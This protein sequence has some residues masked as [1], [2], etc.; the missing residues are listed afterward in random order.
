MVHDRPEIRV[1]LA[2]NANVGKSLIFNQ[3][4]GM[5]QII[6]NWPG[7][8]V[9][10]AE[11][12]FVYK[13]FKIQMID[14]PGIY[15][16]STYSLE[17][18]VSRE[19]IALEKPDIVVNVVDS[20]VLER[21]LFFTLQLLE[22]G[23][24]LVLVLNL[25]DQ[26]EKKGISINSDKLE[27]I[28]GVPVIKTIARTGSGITELV[29]KIIELNEQTLMPPIIKYGK[30]IEQEINHV[31][32]LIQ[33]HGLEYP[34]RWLAIKILENDTEIIK[35]LTENDKRLTKK[36]LPHTKELEDIHG[37]PYDLVMTSEK[38]SI[39]NRIA[40]S[41]ITVQKP[42]KRPLM[43]NFEKI[44]THPVW[45]I[46]IM[47]LIIL[48]IF[49]GIF[50]FSNFISSFLDDFV[51]IGIEPAIQWLTAI[52]ANFA[53]L[54][55]VPITI[56]GQ[57]IWAGVE[58]FLGGITI[59]LPFIVPFY[60]L[61]AVLEDSGY[62]TRIAFLMDNV[63][64]RVGLH[65]KA[66]IPMIL[67]YGCNVPGCIACQIMETRRE[68][69]IAAFVTTLIPC[70]AVS[71]VVL[72][73][74]SPY[75]VLGFSW[76]VFIYIFNLAIVFILGRIAF[77]TIPGEPSGLI[78]EMHPYRVPSTS[79]VLKQTWF[80]SKGFIYRA[81]PFIILVGVIVKLL[82]ILSILPYVQLFLSPITVL[83]L[84]LP[85]EVGILLVL[86][87]L[88]K[89]LILVELAVLLPAVTVLPLIQAITL[90]VVTMFYIP[91]VATIAVIA[92]EFGYKKAIYM[93]MVE[94]S[95]AIF[96][97]G[98][99]FRVLTFVFFLI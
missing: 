92:R 19:H 56:S 23:R 53:P 96:L 61:L 33:D 13:D 35:I 1:A 29:K 5:S 27:E 62:L 24:P 54:F 94:I 65:G 28:L 69:L 86:G 44:S 98:I 79:V 52:I 26:A 37:E 77:K 80:R 48:S 50:A 43:K 6:G 15:S 63:M 87:F 10:K 12:H 91:C 51:F 95:F 38:Y 70:A 72:G 88:R 81:F 58:S 76:A 31:S 82:E 90:S 74:L 49:L 20:T 47:L 67:G 42:A 8:T 3:L 11:G 2:G 45:G 75:G 66:F 89:E 40:Q 22:L 78:M 93:T 85:I 34:T 59:V 21:N 14:L 83:W 32:Q 99:F 64:H 68:R 36:I 4:T 30:E 17:E 71:V 55:T 60:I 84:G 16:L 46:A 73:L 39:A 41:V 97:G 7:K 57:L 25:T 18:I 9:M